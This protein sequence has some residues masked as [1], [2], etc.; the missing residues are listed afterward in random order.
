[1][2]NSAFRER[3]SSQFSSQRGWLRYVQLQSVIDLETFKRISVD[4]DIHLLIG[5]I[6]YLLAAA[7]NFDTMS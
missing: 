7:I 2:A 3:F 5:I 4:K 1:M 6:G